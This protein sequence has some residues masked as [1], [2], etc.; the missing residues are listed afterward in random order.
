MHFNTSIHTKHSNKCGFV[1]CPPT[2]KICFSDWKW[3]HFLERRLF[4]INPK[5]GNVENK[6]HWNLFSPSFM[7]RASFWMNSPIYS[8][9]HLNG[10]Y[11]IV[12]SM[13]CVYSI[14]DFLP[15]HFKCAEINSTIRNGIYW[16]MVWWLDGS[17]ISSN[18]ERESE[19]KEKREKL[20]Y[21]ISVQWFTDQSW[22]HDT[23]VQTHTHIHT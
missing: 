7:R 8:C 10:F 3:T 2:H 23:A 12:D 1:S 14:Y 19:P 6:I 21:A 13:V 17:G 22:E 5:L 16:T 15:S 20:K 4:F 18:S 11:S 9:K